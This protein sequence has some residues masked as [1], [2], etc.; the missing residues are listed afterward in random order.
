MRLESIG[1]GGF[2]DASLS[3]RTAPTF[4]QAHGTG[5]FHEIMVYGRQYLRRGAHATNHIYCIMSS[6]EQ[7]CCCCRACWFQLGSSLVPAWLH[8][9]SSLIPGWFHLVLTWFQLGSS[10]VPAWFQLGYSLVTAWFH[11]V[12][13]WFQL[14]SSLVPALFQ[15]GSSLV[16]AW[17]QLGT[18]LVP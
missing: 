11:L 18:R 14:G 16:P 8:L 9:G 15:A 4:G 5:S 1:L 6:P 13:A 12:P 3:C 17:F 10:L 2:K 7:V